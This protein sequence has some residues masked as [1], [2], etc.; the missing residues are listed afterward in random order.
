MK[1]GPLAEYLKN[2]AEHLRSEE[3]RR[4]EA[5]AEWL[6]ALERLY[7]QLEQWSLDADGGFRL[8]RVKR[9]IAEYEEPRLGIYDTSI[10]ILRLGSRSVKVTPRARY[11]IASIRPPGQEP[12][13]ADGMVEIKGESVAEYYLFRIKYEAGD[14][15]FIQSIGEWNSQTISGAVEPLTQHRF[16]EAILGILK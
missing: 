8:L 16:E 11:V 2:E 10:L 12:R 1:M 14:S 9:L 3:G 6:A 13:R 5:R 7:K 15:W 4:E